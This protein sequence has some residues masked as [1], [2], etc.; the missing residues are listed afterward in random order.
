[1]VTEGRHILVKCLKSTTELETFDLLS[2]MAFPLKSTLRVPP[3][4]ESMQENVFKEHSIN[5]WCGCHLRNQNGVVWYRQKRKQL[6]LI[7]SL[8]NLK[9]CQI[10]APAA[11]VPTRIN[12][13]AGEL[14]TSAASAYSKSN[15]GDLVKAVTK[16]ALPEH[17]L[18]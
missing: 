4:A 7:K 1:M 11:N 8:P 13:T 3:S 12:V 6:F 2:L 16:K 9:A 14:G 15:E 10:L 17:H 18:V 5:N